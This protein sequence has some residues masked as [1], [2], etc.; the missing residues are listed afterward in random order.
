MNLVMCH[1][2]QHC[3]VCLPPGPS[4]SGGGEGP[5]CEYP[6]GCSEVCAEEESERI[7]VCCEV[8]HK[9]EERQLREFQEWSGG[10]RGDGGAQRGHHDAPGHGG[11][12]YSHDR[13]C[14]GEFGL[15]Q[16]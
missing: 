5:S 1:M 6:A 11:G 14:K 3:C 10:Q 8:H 4:H 16:G 15:Y 9:G 7:L 12:F 13:S 2:Q